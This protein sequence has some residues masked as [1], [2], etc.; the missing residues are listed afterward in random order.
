MI[1]NKW[2]NYHKRKPHKLH[3]YPTRHIKRRCI[4]THTY[5]YSSMFYSPNSSFFCGK[6]PRRKYWNWKMQ[7]DSA[8]LLYTLRYIE[9][10]MFHY[11][12]FY[13]LSFGMCVERQQDRLSE[14]VYVNCCFCG[15]KFARGYETTME[16]I[17]QVILL[18]WKKL[19]YF[20]GD[21]IRASEITRERFKHW[22]WGCEC[23]THATYNLKSIF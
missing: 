14:C 10:P 18:I 11:V 9:P 12:P 8:S 13:F 23:D 2:W 17:K 5:C 22:R 7:I 21:R 4:H 16:K 15:G 3:T 6:P 20:P 19:E 1:K